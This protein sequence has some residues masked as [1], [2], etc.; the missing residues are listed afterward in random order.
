[1][2]IGMTTDVYHRDNCIAPD[3][4]FIVWT[5]FVLGCEQGAQGPDSKKP[6][7][8]YPNNDPTVDLRV[9]DIF[10]A[11]YGMRTF[12]HQV[13]GLSR[14]AAMLIHKHATKKDSKV[15]HCSLSS[16][17]GLSRAACVQALIDEATERLRLPGRRF[18]NDSLDDSRWP[19]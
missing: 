16:R 12:H 17:P 10:R 8:R 4:A 5:R 7:L 6:P 13:S 18:L 11:M 3:I 14:T 19:R 15:V 9:K 1:M 2:A